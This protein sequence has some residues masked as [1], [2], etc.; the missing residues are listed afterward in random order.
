MAHM[1]QSQ[2]SHKVSSVVLGGVAHFPQNSWFS[3]NSSKSIRGRGTRFCMIGHIYV[4]YMH[5]K[6]QTCKFNNNE[7]VIKNMRTDKIWSIRVELEH[8]PGGVTPPVVRGNT[9]F[10]PLCA[11]L[12]TRF[13]QLCMELPTR[14]H[15]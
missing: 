5:R 12:P 9:R 13:H 15:P 6:F 4:V 3:I 10:H 7:R 14:F 8:N 2:L 1:I 11:E